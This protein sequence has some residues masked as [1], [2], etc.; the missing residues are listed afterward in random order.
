M[1]NK[2]KWIDKVE[3]NRG[4]VNFF[5]NNNKII[6]E[7]LSMIY[8]NQLYGYLPKKNKKVII[9][10]TSANPNG[11]LHVG[12]TRNPIIGDT[13]VRIY[14]AAGYDVESQFY[15]DDMGKQVAILA[16]G[17]KNI[18]KSD[19]NKPTYNKPDH[20]SVGYYQKASELMK[21]DKKISDLISK[22]IKKSEHGDEQT[23]KEIHEAYQPVLKGMLDSL[24]TINV[25]IDSFIPESK[26]VNDKSVDEVVTDLKKSKY[27]KK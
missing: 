26:F 2:S 19:I 7:T 24:N 14:R 5:I 1:I 8:K 15:L 10:H 25:Q 23:L 3:S 6:E 4:Y 17:I 22:I 9:E 11:P 21:K 12:R 13:M 20:K 16:W 27:F 18:K